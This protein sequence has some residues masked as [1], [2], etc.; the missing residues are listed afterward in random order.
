MVQVCLFGV[1]QAHQGMV[2]AD[3]QGALTNQVFFNQIKWCHQLTARNVLF[4]R[5][6]FV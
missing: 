4:G 3:H 6:H 5:L 1:S 2:V